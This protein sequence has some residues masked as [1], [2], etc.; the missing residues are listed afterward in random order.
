MATL[1]SS[2]IE[3]SLDDPTPGS[4]KIPLGMGLFMQDMDGPVLPTRVLAAARSALGKIPE[5]G[6]W[7]AR[8]EGV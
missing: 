5:E 1:P 2:L 6:D 7:G 8:N 4:P 3:M